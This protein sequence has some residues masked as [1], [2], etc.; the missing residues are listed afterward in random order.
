[1]I[2]S[3]KL[4][5]THKFICIT[6]VIITALCSGCSSI[7]YYSHIIGGHLQIHSS[8]QPIES[9]LSDSDTDDILRQKLKLIQEA[10]QFA[11]T[12]LD[13]PQ[14]D[15]Y[16][17]YAD[18]GRKYVMWSV[19]ATPK[20]SLS[21]HQS[22]FIIVGCMNYR[23]FFAKED[24]E[25]F[26]KNMQD[27]GYDTY[28]ASVAAFSSLGWFDDPVLNT[29]LSWR[30]TRL[31]GLIFHELTHQKIYVNDDTTFNESLAVTV[32]MEGIKKWLASK[33]ETDKL[34]EF[35]KQ[36]KRHQQFLDLVLYTRSQLN[37]L[38]QTNLNNPEKLTKKDA[39]FKSLRDGYKGLKQN[40]GGYP[41]YDR[42]FAKDLN[43]AKLALLSTYSKY[44]PALT[45][46][47]HEN[48]GDFGKF[49]VKVKELATLK[50]N[51]RDLF[52]ETSLPK[53]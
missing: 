42:W 20:L 38:Y 31:A 37:S 27:Q 1:M 16:S 45:Q 46:I 36:S 15:S 48:N 29:M 35:L 51:E 4:R 22:C 13:L 44:V 26:A 25:S 47:L 43:N 40:W 3:K 49:F 11:V 7:G 10:K 23:T 21:P 17:E 24:A 33:G 39:I 12:K 5:N 53:K 2:F 8:T 14:N 41:G 6:A 50:K 19:T 18:L 32:E 34:Q 9:I 52:L 30:D 28:I